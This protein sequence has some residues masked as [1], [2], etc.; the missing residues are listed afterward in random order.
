LFFDSVGL[1]FLL[2]SLPSACRWHRFGLGILLGGL[3]VAAHPARATEAPGDELLSAPPPLPLLAT[4]AAPEPAATVPGDPSGGLPP[5]AASAPTP[6]VSLAAP[7]TTASVAALIATPSGSASSALSPID[8]TKPAAA[9]EAPLAVRAM[10]VDATPQR[11]ASLALL[12]PQASPYAPRYAITPERRALL[13]TIR[14]SEGTWARGEDSGYRIMFGGGL[15]ASLERHPDRVNYS[16]GYASAAAGAYQFMPFTWAR[17]SR[18]LQL[19]GFGPHVQDQAALFLVERRGALALADQGVF[20]PDLA[21][22]L[23]P[24]WASFPTLSG[25][26]YYGQPVQRYAVLRS[27][28]ERNLAEL[29][30]S[31]VPVQP[32]AS[33]PAC[34]PVESL[35]CRLEAL[36][37]LGPRNRPLGG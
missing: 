17:A 10:P 9:F 32:V 25:S 24:E 4:A 33:K 30:A 22:L 19:Q 35:R 14:F 6:A 7:A 13:N 37:S 29:R 23:A 16:G 11:P 26:S 8:S 36:E 20:S 15:M 3:T 2:R 31:L 21:A 12:D 5:D 34:E 18:A 28:Y 1:Q 27:F